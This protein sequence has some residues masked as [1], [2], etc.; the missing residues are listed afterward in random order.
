MKTMRVMYAASIL[1]FVSQ[2][3]GIGPNMW[4]ALFG[5]IGIAAIPTLTVLWYLDEQRERNS[6]KSPEKPKPTDGA[7]LK[8]Q[9]TGFGILALIVLI[10]WLTS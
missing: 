4:N 1:F 2:I 3:V 9:L 5:I 10:A 7:K 8:A 6:A